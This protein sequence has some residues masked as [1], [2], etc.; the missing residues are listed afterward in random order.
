MLLFLQFCLVHIYHSMLNSPFRRILF[1]LHF[2]VFFQ[3]N[4]LL[5]ISHLSTRHRYRF[6]N[7]F[8]CIKCLGWK[9]IFKIDI[10]M[11]PVNSKKNLST[12]G[13]ELFLVHA[14]N[15]KTLIR[16]DNYT[17]IMTKI[18]NIPHDW[19]AVDHCL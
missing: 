19:T 8:R 17:I 3:T 10:F 11:H 15:I 2:G 18:S 14:L 12:T 1:Q 13:V 5:L 6:S 9:Q 7:N 4:S 16:V